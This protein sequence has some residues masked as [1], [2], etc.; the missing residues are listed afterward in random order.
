MKQVLRRLHTRY[1]PYRELRVD[2]R[3]NVATFNEPVVFLQ[4]RIDIISQETPNADV[5]LESLNS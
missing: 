2:A 5:N 1:P 4:A 3:L